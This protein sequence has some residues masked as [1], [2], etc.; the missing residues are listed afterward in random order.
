[1]RIA[2]ARGRLAGGKVVH[3]L[4]A[5]ESDAAVEQRN[6]DPLSLARHCAIG[7]RRTDRDGGVHAGGHVDDRDA[8][9]LRPAAGHTISFA[10]DAHQSTHALR[11]EIVAGPVLVRTGLAE[12]GDR[13]V[14]QSRVGFG[15]IVITQAVS[16][17][18]TYLVVLDQHI[19]VLRQLAHQ[20]LPF[21]LA[22]V[23]R[24]RFL[25]AIGGA[26]IG[27]LLGLA[28][29]FVFEERGGITT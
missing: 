7:Q 26:E 5:E 28:A 3:R 15:Q 17:Q 12:T 9:A 1:M 13:A 25:A 10:G 23:H 4:I 8:D 6:V 18:I 29:L 24:D 22:Q 20:L 16:R 19:D 11:H 14:D 2:D 21:G 27:A